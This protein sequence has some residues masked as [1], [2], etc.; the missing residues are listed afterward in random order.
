[1]AN[2]LACVVYLSSYR[3]EVAAVEQRLQVLGYEVQSFEV[4]K[5]RAS[6]VQTG[7]PSSL[8]S[9]LRKCLD[10]ADL[11]V[12]LIDEDAD[13]LGAVAGFGSDFGCRVVTV[14]GEPDDVPSDVD[15]IADGHVPDIER[16]EADE[17]LCGK[18]ERIQTDGVAAPVRKPARVKC[19]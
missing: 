10:K 1:M 19:Q 11:C 8:P 4:T 6:A 17:I 18:P 2:N 16:P 13:C 3:G 9:E 15:D 12:L 5:E 14:G 7:D